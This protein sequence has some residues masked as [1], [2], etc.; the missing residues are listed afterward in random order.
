[1]DIKKIIFNLSLFIPIYSLVNYNTVEVNVH[2]VLNRL[3]EFIQSLSDYGTAE[4]MPK[5]NGRRMEVIIKTN[6]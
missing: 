2:K 5:M 1:M 4:N 6:T 3:L